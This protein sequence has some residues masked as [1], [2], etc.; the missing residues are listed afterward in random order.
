MKIRWRLLAALF[1]G[2]LAIHALV[3]ALPVHALAGE[4]ALSISAQSGTEKG[5]EVQTL[6]VKIDQPKEVQWEA[7][8]AMGKTWYVDDPPAF[9]IGTRPGQGD[10]V[11]I[12]VTQRYEQRQGSFQAA[13]GTYYITAR[14]GHGIRNAAGD[15]REFHV[16]GD[17]RGWI[18]F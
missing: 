2:V 12:E 10:I 6:E 7:A 9:L 1:I 15:I 4:D 14:A 16:F 13:P 5:G 11:K 18:D 8:I 3:A 17:A